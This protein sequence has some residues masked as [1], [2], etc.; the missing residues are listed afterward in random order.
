MFAAN[1]TI[2]LDPLQAIFLLI[3]QLYGVT[4]YGLVSD[5]Q[6]SPTDKFVKVIQEVPHQYGF[7]FLGH[8]TNWGTALI[9]N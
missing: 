3:A 9:G 4:Y 2:T 1:Q 8:L 6:T 5:H 7:W